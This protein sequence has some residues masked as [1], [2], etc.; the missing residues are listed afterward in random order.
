MKKERENKR[1]SVGLKLDRHLKSLIDSKLKRHAL[2][3]VF[4]DEKILSASQVITRIT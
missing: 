2:S 4:G 1:Q 3:A